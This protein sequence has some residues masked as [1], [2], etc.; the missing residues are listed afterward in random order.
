MNK[1]ARR[2]HLT[3]KGL[4]CDEDAPCVHDRRAENGHL[5]KLAGAVAGTFIGIAAASATGFLAMG[6]GGIGGRW[7]LVIALASFF[8]GI[9]FLKRTL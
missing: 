6:G 2:P 7:L 3:D 8:V 5:I 9:L 4:L 1:I